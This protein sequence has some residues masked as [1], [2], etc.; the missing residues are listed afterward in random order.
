[1]RIWKQLYLIVWLTFL[2]IVIIL[3]PRLGSL[4][5]LHAVLGFII[6]GLAHYDYAMLKRTNAPNRLKRIAKST[7]V[8]TTFQ[9]ILGI[10]LY[11]NLRLNVSIPLLEVVTF[12][13]LVTALAIITQAASVATAYDMWE[14]HEYT[15]SK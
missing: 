4:V 12:V 14:E 10:I 1:M 15:P 13:H 9:I 3:I 7:A 8:L 11:T 5:D 6:L 2:Q